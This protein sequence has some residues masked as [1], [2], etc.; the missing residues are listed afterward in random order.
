MRFLIYFSPLCGR[1][2]KKWNGR[3]LSRKSRWILITGRNCSATI[4]S[5]SRRIW[6]GIWARANVFA[7]KLTTMMAHR[8]IEVQTWGKLGEMGVSMCYWKNNGVVSQAH[9]LFFFQTGKT[10]S[11]IINQTIQLLLKKGMRTLMRDLKVSSGEARIPGSLSVCENVWDLIWMLGTFVVPFCK[12]N[13]HTT[14]YCALSV[15]L[16]CISLFSS[17]SA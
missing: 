11:Q 13:I 1:R 4:M 3:L 15:L 10:T 17:S 12:G 5:S 14:I 9:V 16:S 8:R 6:L 7:S 2:K